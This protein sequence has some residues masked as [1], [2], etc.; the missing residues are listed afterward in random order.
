M[1]QMFIES[2]KHLVEKYSANC[3]QMA[4]IKTALVAKFWFKVDYTLFHYY[5]LRCP[6][7]LS[8]I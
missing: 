2:H 7:I 5:V 4:K 8:N 6:C 3:V 1:F